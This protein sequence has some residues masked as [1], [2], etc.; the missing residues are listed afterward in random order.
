MR[1]A[2]SARIVPTTVT[3]TYVSSPQRSHCS[4]SEYEVPPP[5]S[6]S[7]TMYR[8]ERKVVHSR[9]S[10]SLLKPPFMK[11]EANVRRRSRTRHLHV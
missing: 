9:L 3:L 11:Y 2:Y 4:R 6:H 5:L 7:A 10:D 1:T 8:W